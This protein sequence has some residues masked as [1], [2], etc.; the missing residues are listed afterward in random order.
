MTSGKGGT[1]LFD[2]PGGAPPLTGEAPAESGRMNAPSPMSSFWRD[3]WRWRLLTP[4]VKWRFM[5]SGGHRP[6]ATMRIRLAW[7]LRPEA[8]SD[9]LP[10]D[11]AATAR[12]VPQLGLSPVCDPILAL[13]IRRCGTK[14]RF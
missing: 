4:Q 2:P 11:A 13:R 14:I 5:R 1:P 9:G 12:V 3:L 8:R 7:A 10:R 6:A